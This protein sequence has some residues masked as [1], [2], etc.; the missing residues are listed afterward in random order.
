M[1]AH[2]LLPSDVIGNNR[3]MI[4]SH[5]VDRGSLLDNLQIAY[6]R[7]SQELIYRGM[8]NEFS[9]RDLSKDSRRTPPL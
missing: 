9:S 7:V 8:D 6:R 2:S 1:G 3:A 5:F 4:A